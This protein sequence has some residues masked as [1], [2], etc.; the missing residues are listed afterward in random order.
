MNVVSTLRDARSALL[1]WREAGETVA[2]V[3]T[4][5]ALHQGHLAL[6]VAAQKLAKHTV[7]SLFVNPIQFAPH[8]DFD[9]YPRQLDRDKQMLSE[10]GCS[11]LY[12]PSP[13][14]IYP[15]GFA[16]SIDPGP[17]ATILEGVFR[18]GFFVGVATVVIKFLMQLMPDIALFG[19]KDYQQ[20]LIIRHIVRDLNVPVHIVG[21]PTVRDPDGLALS[22][23]N[24]YLLPDDR[25]R[26]CALPRTLTESVQMIQQG[27]NI[28]NVLSVGRNK[29]ISA[30][31]S[32]DYLTLADA[33]TLKTSSSARIA[34]S[35]IGGG[36]SWKYAL[37][38]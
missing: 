30:G 5:G 12:A 6:I 31:F 26:A 23:R 38:R 27:K 2:L 16:T 35:T 37:N 22:S 13:E 9:K 33:M 21:V 3:P 7:A 25:H 8:E 20:L 17:M 29:L 19:E 36:A 32:V 24:S 34:R 14:E 1:P 4:M 11:L 15:S 18:P 28:E 10:A